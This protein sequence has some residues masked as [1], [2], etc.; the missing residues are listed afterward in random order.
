MFNRDPGSAVLTLQRSTGPAAREQWSP[1]I[2]A[3]HQVA[4]VRWQWRWGFLPN[5]QVHDLA[6]AAVSRLVTHPEWWA[7]LYVAQVMRQYPTFRDE[8]L[9]TALIADEDEAV[10][11]TVL[12]FVTEAKH[13]G[14]E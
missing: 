7:R 2:W 3:E 5:D 4:D 8:K 10:R 12:E 14:D 11:S 6:K 13:K 1:I 9:I